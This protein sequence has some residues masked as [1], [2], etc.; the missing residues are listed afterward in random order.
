MPSI[1]NVIIDIEVPKPFHS[2]IHDINLYFR[3]YP[4]IPLSEEK[5]L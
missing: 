4:F 1:P 2:F 3:R 5:Q